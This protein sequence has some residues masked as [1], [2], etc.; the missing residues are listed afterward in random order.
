MCVA[1]GWSLAAI[2]WYYV[3]MVVSRLHLFSLVITIRPCLFLNQHH[4]HHHYHRS[5]IS[6]MLGGRIR[7]PS[8]LCCFVFL[9]LVLIAKPHSR[10]Y[11]DCD[12][13]TRTDPVGWNPRS[14]SEFIHHLAS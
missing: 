1:D 4:H 2:L 7:H 14:Q 10:P 6:N 11:K 5:L 9:H 8:K 12:L 3:S 13:S